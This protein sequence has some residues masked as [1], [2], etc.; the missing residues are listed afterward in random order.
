MRKA[1]CTVVKSEDSRAS[2]PLSS[3]RSPLR[4]RGTSHLTFPH[5]NC[6]ISKVG[7]EVVHTS[8]LVVRLKCINM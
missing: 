5:P 8:H 1:V 4:D 7:M 3:P 6:F 2:L